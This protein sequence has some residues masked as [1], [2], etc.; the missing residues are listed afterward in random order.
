MSNN[1]EK[2]S[3]D[4]LQFNIPIYAKFSALILSRTNLTHTN[5]MPNIHDTQ[6]SEQSQSN[7]ENQVSEETWSSEETLAFCW[8]G[9]FVDY[10]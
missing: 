7:E 8:R 6:F 2:G 3:Y 1:F 4:N 9:T 5:H 10:K